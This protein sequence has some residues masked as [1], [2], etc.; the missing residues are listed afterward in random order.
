MFPNV[1]TCIASNG[2]PLHCSTHTH[3]RSHSLYTYPFALGD[4]G[5]PLPL[6][7]AGTLVFK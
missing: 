1:C 3:Y 5:D 6:A 7:V 4:E 2:V